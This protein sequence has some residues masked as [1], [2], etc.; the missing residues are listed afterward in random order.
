M[1]DIKFLVWDKKD[2]RF[3]EWW[4]LIF[5]LYCWS[6]NSWEVSI[7]EEYFSNTNNNWD[8]N[9]NR[10]EIMQYTWLEDKNWKEIYEFDILE[11]YQKWHWSIIWK[12]VFINWWFEL[13]EIKWNRLWSFQDLIITEWFKLKI[14]WNIWSNP[15]LLDNK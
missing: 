4:E 12:V 5:L 2:K 15:N 10:F 3:I 7:N 11:L 13:R 8:N 9:N 1:R 14:I 6:E